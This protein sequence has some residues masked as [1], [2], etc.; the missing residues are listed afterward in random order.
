MLSSLHDSSATSGVPVSSTNSTVPVPNSSAVNYLRGLVRTRSSVNPTDGPTEHCTTSMVAPYARLKDRSIPFQEVDR[1]YELFSDHS[2]Q[3]LRSLLDAN[4]LITLISGTSESIDV[5]TSQSHCLEESHIDLRIC[6][7]GIDNVSAEVP[8]YFGIQDG[9][10]GCSCSSAASSQ[11]S[12]DLSSFHS[13]DSL[14]AEDGSVYH[15]S[16]FLEKSAKH[17]SQVS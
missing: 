11:L 13:D 12:S 16:A 9:E 1:N 15:A 10:Q 5:N 8:V 3:N 7:S 2:Y 17:H 14:K 6:G 4:Q